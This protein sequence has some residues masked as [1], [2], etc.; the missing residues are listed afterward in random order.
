MGKIYH[1]WGWFGEFCKMHSSKLE[2]REK[3]L[4]PKL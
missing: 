2:G 1:Q 4:I 3:N